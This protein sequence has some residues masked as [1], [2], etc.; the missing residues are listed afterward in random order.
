MS[1]ELYVPEITEAA[2]VLADQVERT[3]QRPEL[4]DAVGNGRRQALERA[5]ERVR[6]ATVSELVVLSIRCQDP[7][8]NDPWEEELRLLYVPRVGEKIEVWVDHDKEQ[9]WLEVND[10]AHCGYWPGVEIWVSTDGHSD[11]DLRRVFDAIKRG[12]KP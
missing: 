6:R 5:L 12:D 10:V 2:R 4:L 1:T 8:G 3:L 9:V 11:A 7:E